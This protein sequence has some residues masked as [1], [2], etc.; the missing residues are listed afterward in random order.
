MTTST[1]VSGEKATITDRTR[2][3][4]PPFA[5]VV[6]AYRGR[7]VRVSQAALLTKTAPFLLAGVLQASDVA[8]LDAAAERFQLADDPE[9]ALAFAFA[10]AA[11]RQG[12]QGVELTQLRAWLGGGRYEVKDADGAPIDL[13]AALPR[14]LA[15]WQARVRRHPAVANATPRPT[16]PFV[17][18]T[19]ETGGP[20]AR[21]EGMLMTCRMWRE[22]RRLAD[23]LIGMANSAVDW[24]PSAEELDRRL[25]EIYDQGDQ[26]DQARDAARRVAEGRLTVITGGPGTGKTFGIKRVLAILLESAKRAGKDLAIE[27]AAPTGKAAVRMAEAMADAG[28]LADFSPNT[29]QT[30]QG[31]EPRTLHKLL[32]VLP[33]KPQ[34]FRHGK[35]HRLGAD[36]VVVDE[37]S[38]I[39]LQMMRHLVE[40][41]ADGKRLVLLG[42]RDQLA[43]VDAGTVLADLV[44]GVF[45][46]TATDSFG[47]RG[48]IARL[49]RSFRF[50]QAASIACVADD[51]QSREPARVE[52]AVAL[53]CGDS[54]ENPAWRAKIDADP[55]DD[56]SRPQRIRSLTLLQPRAEKRPAGKTPPEKITDA[57]ST[58]ILHALLGPYIDP[59]VDNLQHSNGQPH[60]EPQPGYVALLCDRMAA[61]SRSAAGSL[62]DPVWHEALLDA[63]ARYRVLTAHRRG[64]RGVT[65]L[66]TWLA[67]EIRNVLTIG[68]TGAD[69]APMTPRA[70]EKSGNHWLGQPVMVTRNSYEVNLRNG[71]IGLVVMHQP[72][73]GP[74]ALWC[75]FPDPRLKT[76]TRPGVRYVSLA[77]LP[78]HETALA[79]TVHKSQGSQFDRIALVLPAESGS[80]ILTR[81]LVYTGITR[82]KWRVDWVGDRAVLADALRRGVGRASGLGQLLWSEMATNTDTQAR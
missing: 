3:P 64:P 5:H 67:T 14:D 30:L 10:L 68:R 47:L 73:Q 23:V 46:T 72:A 82:A 12:H 49:T 22:Q 51:L 41:I 55:R 48:R 16:A 69:G 81:E 37:A 18:Q 4:A 31:L 20:D 34:G 74:R 70:L 26:D 44:S 52:A 60:P 25:A 77:R 62:T 80:P 24:R 15:A 75:A 40:A 45:V 11:P 29:R 42:D 63:L 66:N 65:G 57:L 38:M 71:D 56:V 33:H 35:G 7:Q 59:A 21:T 27:L 2:V 19:T 61:P 54:P 28:G 50:E 8:I 13:L 78:D 32:G 36:I 9:L 76:E 43:S 58:S 6:P 79:M 53:M 39:D 17:F 1:S